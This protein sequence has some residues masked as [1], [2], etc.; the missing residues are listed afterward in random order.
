MCGS[1]SLFPQGLAY[2]GENRLSQTLGAGLLALRTDK[3]QQ[4]FAVPLAYRFNLQNSLAAGGAKGTHL[5][6]QRLGH[7]WSVQSP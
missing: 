3:K 4:V 6:F 5:G 1:G 7:Q 2:L